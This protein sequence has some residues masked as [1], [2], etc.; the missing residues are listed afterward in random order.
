[1]YSHFHLGGQRPDIHNA[2]QFHC[3]LVI[4]NWGMILGLT[5]TV[6]SVLVSYTYAHWFSMSAQVLAHI[7]TLLFATVVKFGYIMRSI[8]LNRFAGLRAL[9]SPE[10][11]VQEP[12]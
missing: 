7:G 5:L 12:H 11:A 1:M 9:A 4:G 3:L 10:S 2:R 6:L 8:A